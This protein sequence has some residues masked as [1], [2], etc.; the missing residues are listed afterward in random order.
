VLTQPHQQLL[1]Q[2]HGAPP[3]AAAALQACM[4]AGLAPAAL[5][6]VL[7]AVHLPWLGQYGR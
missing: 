5:A 7:V 3:A 6:L 4:H 1:L 2:A